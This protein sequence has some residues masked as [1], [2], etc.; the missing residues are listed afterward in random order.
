MKFEFQAEFSRMHVKSCHNSLSL[1]LLSR[2]CFT[3][4]AC[5]VLSFVVVGKKSLHNALKGKNQFAI[6]IPD[7]HGDEPSETG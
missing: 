5:L 1:W 4:L 7:V 6:C 3:K 2:V